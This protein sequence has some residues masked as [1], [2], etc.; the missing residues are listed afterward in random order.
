MSSPSYVLGTVQI[1]I[2]AGATALDNTPGG[3]RGSQLATVRVIASNGADGTPV[4]P[5]KLQVRC[6]L[7]GDPVADYIVTDCT[8]DSPSLPIAQGTDQLEIKN[9][10]AFAILAIAQYEVDFQYPPR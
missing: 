8:L 6:L 2:A 9:L 4:A 7:G 5:I 3:P 10:A 1:P